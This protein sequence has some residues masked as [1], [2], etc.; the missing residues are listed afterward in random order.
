M[1]TAGLGDRFRGDGTMGDETRAAA[2]GEGDREREEVLGGGTG[3]VDRRGGIMGE[4]IRG[5][6]MDEELL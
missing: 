4:G 5:K 3:E 2:V 1:V 6:G